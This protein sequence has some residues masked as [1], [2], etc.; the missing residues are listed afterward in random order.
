MK[1]TPAEQKALDAA[2]NIK[3]LPAA[4]YVPIRQTPA[5]Q[6]TVTQTRAMLE[7]DLK[8]AAEAFESRERSN[9][10]YRHYLRK[11]DRSEARWHAPSPL[12]ASTQ[13]LRRDLVEA[14]KDLLEF[15]R[16][17]LAPSVRTESKR[18]R[19]STRF[20][21][22]LEVQRTIERNGGKVRHRHRPTRK[23]ILYARLIVPGNLQKETRTP[24]P[25][26]L[27]LGV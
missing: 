4:E 2:K 11:G 18:W 23:D 24:E 7:D 12:V 22:L 9:D 26:Q 5:A 10:L 19:K 17:P 6:R 20:F 15:E 14:W 1:H 25:Q 27:A 13:S 8:H 16:M 21:A 3:P